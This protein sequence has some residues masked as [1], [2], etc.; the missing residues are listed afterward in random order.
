MT[1]ADR[2]ADPSL[3]ACS[4]A[5]REAHGKGGSVGWHLGFQAVVWNPIVYGDIEPP[6]WRAGPSALVLSPV[7]QAVD[8]LHIYDVLGYMKCMNVRT[9]VLGMV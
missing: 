1:D 2:L 7:C 4:E 8:V 5:S 3:P 9:R 6:C